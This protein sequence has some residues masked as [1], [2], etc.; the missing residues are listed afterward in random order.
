MPG[1]KR[2][3][4]ILHNAFLRLFGKMAVLKHV[5]FGPWVALHG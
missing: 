5:T 2:V 1:Q 3:W 4:G